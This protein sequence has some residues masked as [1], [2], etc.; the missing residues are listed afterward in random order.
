MTPTI[1]VRIS[2][3]EDAESIATLCHQLGYPTSPEAVK[4]RCQSMQA[5]DQ[6][7]V[8]VAL[9]N[10]AVVGWVH[11]HVCDLVITPPQILILGLVVDEHHRGCGI[12]RLLMQH[13]EQWAEEKACD[14]ILVRSNVIRT[15]AHLFY[16]HVGYEN[17]KQSKVFAKRLVQ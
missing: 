4:Q 16:Q 9:V 15:D 12:G 7:I 6:H 8:Y 10:E 11:G 13:I 5:N 3:P 2:Q 14:T 1:T 17:I